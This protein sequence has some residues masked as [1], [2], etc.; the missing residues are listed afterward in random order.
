MNVVICMYMRD[1]W[2]QNLGW[3]PW[4]TVSAQLKLSYI[5]PCNT[6]LLGRCSWH[7]SKEKKSLAVRHIISHN[8]NWAVNVGFQVLVATD[9]KITVLWGVARY[10]L[11]RTDWHFIGA[12]WL[13]HQVIMPCCSK[14]L[15]HHSICTTLHMVQHNRRQSLW[16][17]KVHS[18]V[19]WWHI[20]AC[21]KFF[22]DTFNPV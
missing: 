3:L 17:V 14:H 12:Y 21:L 1:A 22:C 5:C 2:L 11:V 10:S 13:Y 6:Y 4:F 7:V 20:N 19:C 18:Y 16:S 15:K 9:I 8:I